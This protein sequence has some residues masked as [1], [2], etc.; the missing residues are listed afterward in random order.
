MHTL[1]Y[2]IDEKRPDS[3]ARN[4]FPSGH[5]AAAFSGASFIQRRYGWTLGAP[6]YA[7]ATFVGYSRV[8]AGAHYVHDTLAG[9]AIAVGFTYLFT[10][11]RADG[12]R[13]AP[14]VGERRTGLRIS[15]RF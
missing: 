6:A 14:V 15:G 1:K 8:H 11:P 13:I 5:T 2:A 10:E 12:L 3:E 9:A 4:S 7:L